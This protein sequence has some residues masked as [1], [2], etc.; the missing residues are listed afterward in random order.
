MKPHRCSF[1]ARTCV[2]GCQGAQSKGCHA[3]LCQHLGGAT[4]VAPSPPERAL[5]QPRARPSARRCRRAGRWGRKRAQVGASRLLLALGALLGAL[6]G[7]ALR[8]RG[9]FV[10]SRGLMAAA[11]S[12]VGSAAVS[13]VSSAPRRARCAQQNA[14]LPRRVREF[15][16]GRSR[17]TQSAPIPCR[18]LVARARRRLQGKHC[19]ESDPQ[20]RRGL[21]AAPE[22]S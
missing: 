8:L 18:A 6:L 2:A 13:L 20:A 21:L 3:P 11:G 5:S 10:L 19:K 17:G 22:L 4:P 1:D 16:T 15:K 7:K 14:P 12:V 9:T